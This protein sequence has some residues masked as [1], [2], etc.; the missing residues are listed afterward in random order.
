VFSGSHETGGSNE[1]EDSAVHGNKTRLMW[2]WEVHIQGFV[3]KISTLAVECLCKLWSV[4]S[5][6]LTWI[7]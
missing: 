2:D 3:G 7:L 6:R 5:E 1:E 4:A